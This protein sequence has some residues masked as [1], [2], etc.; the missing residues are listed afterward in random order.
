MVLS[1]KQTHDQQNGIESLEINSHT[2]SQLICDKG[3]KNIQWRKDSSFNKCFWK[4]Q[5]ATY[6]RIKLEHSVT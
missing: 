1:Q 4:N 3:G 2:Y 5:I 6:K